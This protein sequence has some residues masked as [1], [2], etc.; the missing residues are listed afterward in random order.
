MR[1]IVIASFLSSTGFFLAG[2]VQAASLYLDP[3]FTTIY[4]GDSVTAAV[5]VDTDEQMNECINAADVVI[6]Y[7]ASIQPVDVS[8][9][10]SIFSVW[11]EAPV[12]DT[13]N[14]TISFAGGIPNGYCGRIE[15]DPRLSNVIAK[16][17]FRSP[18]LQIGGG[19]DSD[20]A[21]ISFAEGSAMYLNDGFGTQANLTTFPSTIT[22]ERNPGAEVQDEWRDDVKADS[23]PPQQF[24]IE[25]ARDDK[26]FSG[27]YFIVF[28]TTDKET[29]I[30]HYEVIEEPVA[31]WA[32]FRWG[33]ADAPWVTTRSPYVLKDQSLN[34]IIRVKAVDKAGNE[35]IAT[36]IPEESLRS[37]SQ[38][39]V[40]L[41]VAAATLFV[42]LLLLVLFGVIWVRRRR[43]G[44]LVDATVTDSAALNE[45]EDGEVK[46]DKI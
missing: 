19:S 24:G 12:I 34:S 42:L 18:G 5:R 32:G 9:G 1:G 17:V 16:I 14:R 41:Y 20:K 6:H 40:L 38:E 46:S 39:W 11:V 28:N 35:Y 30:S 25:L 31:D 2:H 15:G 37:L 7:D 33:R 3:A 22:L 36:Y 27:N 8:I 29:G 13:Q 10:D 26:A 23:N 21:V 43:R 45:G 4:R 44:V